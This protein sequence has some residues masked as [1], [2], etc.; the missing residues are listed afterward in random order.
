MWSYDYLSLEKKQLLP[1]SIN[2][3]KLL[4]VL[5]KT[6]IVTV[7]KS[8]EITIWNKTKQVG[9]SFNYP[10]REINATKAL[11]NGY[12]AIAVNK[13]V[14][15]Y[16]SSF[17]LIQSLTHSFEVS[18]IDVSA[19]T[20]VTSE[21]N[22]NQLSM[23]NLIEKY[24][25]KRNTKLRNEIKLLIILSNETI[26]AL[27]KFSLYSSDL[28]VFDH[29]ITPKFTI[30]KSDVSTLI[31]LNNTNLVIGFI[32]GKI[33]IWNITSE[34]NIK[35]LSTHNAL[36]SFIE[37]KKYLLSIH[38][39]R[40]ILVWDLHSF[41]IKA[42]INENN[43]INFVLFNQDLIRYSKD[44]INVLKFRSKLKISSIKS[45]TAQSPITALLFFFQ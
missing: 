4:T 33:E 31:E 11:S 34:L 10:K 20:L 9:S 35:I 30:E 29:L 38:Q 27:I 8:N 14:E 25:N 44:S 3:L 22:G 37:Y 5:N 26:A 2:N 32:T 17:S 24:E 42:K 19:K 36:K 18:S 28:F 1:E 15:I 13:I 12:L 16:D 41:T 6:L 40:S 7:S 43:N 23:W 21:R 39:D 45:I